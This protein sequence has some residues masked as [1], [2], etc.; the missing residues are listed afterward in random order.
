Q[1]KMYQRFWDLIHQGI[2]ANR[3]SAI[4]AG[5]EL[6]PASLI[7]LFTCKNRNWPGYYP[8]GSLSHRQI[9]LWLFPEQ[10][11]LYG[12]SRGARKVP[13]DPGD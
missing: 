7:L 1:L 2:N 5:R 13:S 11:F 3:I 9:A 6:I 4:W 8:A 10:L 12:D